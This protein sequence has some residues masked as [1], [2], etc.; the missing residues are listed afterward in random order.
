M[1]IG[2]AYNNHKSSLTHRLGLQFNFQIKTSKNLI[3]VPSS[4]AT[5]HCSL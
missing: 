5:L 2:T 4:N 1:K 3:S